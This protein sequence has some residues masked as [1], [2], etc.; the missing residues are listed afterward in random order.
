MR[1]IVNYMDYHSN[2]SSI[3]D[4]FEK[5]FEKAV[6]YILNQSIIRAITK[7]NLQMRE[8]PKYLELF[9]NIETKYL[10]NETFEINGLNCIIQLL[11]PLGLAL[12]FCDITK[13]SDFV[14]GNAEYLLKDY[15]CDDES[16]HHLMYYVRKLSRNITIGTNDDYIE[17]IKNIISDLYNALFKVERIEIGQFEI[18]SYIRERFKRI[19]A[20]PENIV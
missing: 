4:T 15:Y 14:N 3:C 2:N 1:L 19:L 12:K 6:S 16:I 7:Y 5:K 11:L 17:N 20:F 10:Q 13:Y 8:I 18:D 9:S